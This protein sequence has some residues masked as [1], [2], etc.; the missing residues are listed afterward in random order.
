MRSL[1]GNLR[2]IFSPAAAAPKA[3]VG[4]PPAVGYVYS[5]LT[6]PF[7]EFAASETGR[8]AAFKIIGANVDKLVV[9]VYDGIW[10]SPPSLAEFRKAKVLREHRFAHTGR[11]AI[12]GTLLQ[13]WSVDDFKELRLIGVDQPSRHELMEAEKNFAHA[14]G[15]RTASTRFI[16]YAAEGEWRWANDRTAFEDEM[17]QKKEKEDAVR[18]AAEER[19]KNRLSKL[20]WQQLLSEPVFERWS[21]SPPFPPEKFA[22]AAREKIRSTCHE[23]QEL[24]P[25][26]RKADVRRILKD[27]V[28]WFNRVDDEAGGVIETEEREDICAILEEMA[29]VAKQKSLVEE[30]DMWRDW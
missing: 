4:D 6:S 21:P 22:A 15:S 8:Y 9:A 1:F 12:F 25:K 11:E 7:S 13:W 30:V 5:L 20:T 26:P 28:L 24:G 10:P 2:N 19:Y 3:D 16:N 23:L 18:K 17:R 14:V 27:C 29:F